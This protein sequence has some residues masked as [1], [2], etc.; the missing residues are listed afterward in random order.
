LYDVHFK[1]RIR[2][3][4]LADEQ[5][6]DWDTKSAGNVSTIPGML[7]ALRDS[8]QLAHLLFRTFREGIFAM[9]TLATAFVLTLLTVVVSGAA[10]AQ[11]VQTNG[12][13]GCSVSSL[14]VNGTDVFAG[15]EYGIYHSTDDGA[16]WYTSNNGL[17]HSSINAIAKVDANIFVGTGGGGVF[18]STNNGVNWTAVNNGLPSGDFAATA[19]AVSGTNLF[20]CAS[21]WGI[22]RSTN[23]GSSWVPVDGLTSEYIS[24]LVTSGTNILAATADGQG[25]FRSTDNGSSWMPANNGLPYGGYYFSHL[26]ASGTNL[27]A[28][29]G[30]VFRSTNNGESWTAANAPFSNV[31]VMVQ[32]DSELFAGTHEGIYRSTDSGESWTQNGLAGRLVSSLVHTS[33]NLFVGTSAGVFRSND[34]SANWTPVNNGLMST[35]NALAVIDSILFAG[36]N[37]GVFRSSNNG[38]NWILNDSGLVGL[39]IS[40]LAVSDTDLFAGTDFNGVFHSTN[41]GLSWTAINNGLPIGFSGNALAVSG[42]N[43]FAGT[44]SSSGQGIYHSTDNGTTW[45]QTA[46]NWQCV[47]ALAINGTTIFAGLHG[48][49]GRMPVPHGVKV[50]TNNGST[51]AYHGL[52]TFFI[53]AFGVSG[54]SVFAG[55]MRSGIFLSTD[56]GANWAMTGLNTYSISAFVVSGTN[57]F[58]AANDTAGDG[59]YLST[60]NGTSWTEVSTGLPTTTAV[61]KLA[62]SGTDLIA[63]TYGGGVWQRP[64][65][66]M[67]TDVQLSRHELPI[68]YSLHQ[69]YPN[70]FNPSTTISYQLPRQSHVT[71]KVFDVLGREVAT[72]VNAIEPPGFKSINFNSN[73]LSTGVY[74]YRLQASSYVDTK[75]LVLTR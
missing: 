63:G 3:H 48:F 1:R 36:I 43:L 11:W 64:L 74:Y 26:A 71:L 5:L 33:T 21:P 25:V 51:W 28:S 35:V 14:V 16:S 40:S 10:R 66:E 44:R 68:A 32:V 65:S 67:I 70:P 47:R 62:V 18:L 56:N 41:Y 60:N 23:N 30:G 46:V 75:K 52:D 15:T 17:T 13:Y 20:V 54:T 12:P 9:R 42:M 59:I 45:I 58:V 49:D 53:D 61:H 55:G 50:S 57:I 34:N 19:F 2:L 24:A 7:C 31:T 72:L 29:G 4:T 6:A 38:A 37:D 8:A 39:N 69:N 73:G 22:F 27:L